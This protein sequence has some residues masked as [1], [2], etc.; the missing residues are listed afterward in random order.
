VVSLQNGVENVARIQAEAPQLQV[1]A[2]M[3]PYN[4][5]QRDACHVH[6]ASGGHIVLAAGEATARMLPHF[7]AAGLPLEAAADMRAVQWGKLLLNLN[8]PVNALSD[9]P[10]REQLM[11]RDYRL[12][13]AALQREALAALKGA[14]IAPAKVAA[15]PPQLLPWILRLPDWLYV[16]LAAR[17]LQMD[18]SARSSMWVD[19]QHGRVT[20]IDDLCGAVLRLGAAH[21]VATPCNAAMCRLL[22]RYQKGQHWSG[23][24][25]RRAIGV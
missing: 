18:A 17:M 22:A 21:G 12:V 9:L 13:L 1:L 10:L 8:N 15:A 20:E 5:V 6:R 3:V 11:N 7:E 14:G 23:P 24:E 2:G 19:L 25:L 4:V 16:R